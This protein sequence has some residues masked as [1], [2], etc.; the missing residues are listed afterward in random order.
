MKQ[1][2][3]VTGESGMLATAIIKKLKEHSDF[4]DIVNEWKEFDEFRTYYNDYHF[5]NGKKIKEFEIDILHEELIDK[6]IQV[7]D[8]KSII[9]HTAAYVNTDKCEADPYEAVK[10]NVLGT[11]NLIDV[12]DIT[13]CYLVNF[14]T[15][16]VFDPTE[17]MKN[18]GVFDESAKVDP[19]TIYGLTKY[20]AE[21]AVKQSLKHS[22]YI[23][24]KPVFIYGDFPFDNSSMLRKIMEKAYKAK[25]DIEDDEKLMVFLGQLIPKDYMY[26]EFFGDMFFEILK[27]LQL[28]H[29]EDFIISRNYPRRFADY[30]SRIKEITGVN[31]NSMENIEFN[32]YGDYLQN[33][34]G[35]SKN[36]YK[37]FPDFE[38]NKEAYNDYY[39]L[40]KLYNSI[41]KYYEQ[42]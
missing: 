1:K 28:F 41:K 2:V 20:N 35:I 4:Y 19:K 40:Q 5:L 38:L 26:Y 12:V 17:Y 8:N 36:F 24:I 27:N 6:L 16:A 34:N 18:K 42:I 31:V 22:R 25:V 14:S 32:H 29:H 39:G 33:H 3:F 30:L 15:T 10:T 13:D 21:L 11:Q 23:T 37:W 7:L 9:I